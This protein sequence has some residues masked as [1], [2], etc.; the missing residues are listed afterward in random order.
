MFSPLLAAGFN[1]DDLIRLAPFIIALLVWVINRFAST[2]PKKPPQGRP[3]QAK[4]AAPPIAK[5]AND[6]LQSE[7]DEFLRQAKS[8]RE[9]KPN[10]PREAMAQ[11][12]AS[13]QRDAFPPS[14]SSQTPAQRQQR[15]P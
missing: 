11:R 8:L 6:P 1:W 9:G 7:I 10:Q 2:A 4:P 3:V 5:Q 15:P 12:D 13:R 14:S